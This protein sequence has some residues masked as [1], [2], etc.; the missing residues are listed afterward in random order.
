MYLHFTVYGYILNEDHNGF[1]DGSVA[2]NYRIDGSIFPDMWLSLTGQVAQYVV[3]YPDRCSTTPYNLKRK[4]K[5]P[6]ERQ[7]LCT[8]IWVEEALPE[9]AFI[10]AWNRLV[11]EKERHL[12]EWQRAIEGDYLLKAYRVRELMGLVGKIG[13]INW[14]PY[15]L[16]LKTLDH[17]E[18]GME[19][20]LDVV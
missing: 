20:E 1:L 17:I 11:D 4:K 10:K 7:M 15:E 3:E 8:D 2:L 19:G 12:P 13:I 14:M 16:V 6:K 18:I 9:R 5:K